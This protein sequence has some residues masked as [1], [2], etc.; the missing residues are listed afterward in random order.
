MLHELRQYTIVPGEMPHYLKNIADVGGPIRKDQY[1][2]LLGF[3]IN[4]FGTGYEVF[5]LWE[6]EDFNAR[7]RSR[8][9]LFNLEPWK[10]LLPQVEPRIQNQEVRL[11]TPYVQVHMP[12]GR[13]NIYEI[14]FIRAKVGK[15]LALAAGLATEMPIDPTVTQVIGM[16]TTIAGDPNEIVHVSAHS[17]LSQRM[18]LTVQHQD[19]MAFMVKYGPLIE[20]MKSNVVVP[21]KHSPMQ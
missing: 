12:N 17:D 9:E 15:A 7:Q 21:A 5:H 2:K 13:A 3:W 6:H 20:E 19:W 14:R 4:E 11:L 16:W 1:G 18:Q 8:A 10:Q